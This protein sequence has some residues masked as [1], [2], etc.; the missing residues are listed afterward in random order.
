MNTFVNAIKEEQEIGATYNG[1]KTNTTSGS[2]ILDLFAAAGNRDAILG[3]QFDIA[4]AEDP[5]L[6]FRVALWARDIR[7]G[8]GERQTFRNLLLHFEKHYP[9]QLLKIIPVVPSIGRWDDLFIFETKQVKEAVYTLVKMVLTLDVPEYK[10]ARGLLAKWL[11][12]RGAVA[13]EISEFLGYE[14]TPI[15]VKYS[16]KE[17]EEKAKQLGVSIDDIPTDTGRTVKVPSAGYR[18]LLVRLTKVVEQQMCAKKWDEIVFDHVPSVAAAR[19]QKAFYK[20]APER[21]KEYREG[22]TKVKADGTT[23]RKINAGAVYPYDVIKSVGAGLRDVAQAQWN[24]LPNFLG[25]DRI[26]PLVDV[27]GSMYSWSWRHVQR[28]KVKSN[29]MPIDVAVSI[30]LYV[31]DKQ[32]GPFK[33]AFLTFTS[34]PQLQKL[35]GDLAAKVAQAKRAP[36]GGSTNIAKAFSKILELAQTHNVPAEDMPKI[37]LILSDMEFDACIDGHGR[38]VSAFESLVLKYEKAGYTLPKVIFWNING[39]ADNAP[40]RQHESGAALVSGFSPSIFKAVLKADL[41]NYTPY[42]V[43]LQTLANPLYDIEGLTT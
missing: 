30:G 3:S 16:K 36:W 34:E 25:D 27:S 26:L 19:Y 37:L 38:S 40:V 41:E 18:K 42:N 28:A 20:N 8:A 6:A 33:D 10:R 13:L 2:A 9:D 5:K 12:R 32:V 11:P 21:Y 31:A 24:A 43:M 29:V 39:R 1:A 22:L 15:A 35:S 4:F 7:T 17:R 23:E 14:N